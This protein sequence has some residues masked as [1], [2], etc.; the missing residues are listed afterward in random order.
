MK[1]VLEKYT[2]RTF[3]RKN[4][5]EKEHSSV[6]KNNKYK[7]IDSLSHDDIA[8]FQLKIDVNFEPSERSGTIETFLTCIYIG[9][10][11]RDFSS[12]QLFLIVGAD[13]L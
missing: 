12:F 7:T 1:K 8:I 9:Q 6:E 3:Q 4:I 11:N 5:L 10:K 2:L 13:E